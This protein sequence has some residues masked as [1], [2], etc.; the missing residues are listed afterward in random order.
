MFREVGAVLKDIGKVVLG[1]AL[2]RFSVPEVNK[3]MEMGG[4]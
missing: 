3:L 1:S 4:V 2:D